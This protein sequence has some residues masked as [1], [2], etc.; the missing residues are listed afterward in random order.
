MTRS[1]AE[2]AR[3]D[4]EE[5]SAYRDPDNGDSEFPSDFNAD[6]AAAAN[7]A[8]DHEFTA[9]LTRFGVPADLDP[10]NSSW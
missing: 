5:F 4:D 7:A 10:D 3:S 2:F 8:G 6:S 9:M 1:G